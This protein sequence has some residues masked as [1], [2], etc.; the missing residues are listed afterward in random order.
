MAALNYVLTNDPVLLFQNNHL[1]ARETQQVNI[2]GLR[3]LQRDIEALS[4]QAS[5]LVANASAPTPSISSENGPP[6]IPVAPAAPVPQVDP[7]AEIRQT[8]AIILSD[9]VAEYVQPSARMQSYPEA[10]PA[11]VAGVLDRLARYHTSKS[12]QSKE[13]EMGARRMR[14]R[15]QVARLRR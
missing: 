2:D 11:K 15:D 4:N 5:R 10:K 13:Q 6:A 3:Q 14:E 9:A 1:L 7:W 8:L 12:G